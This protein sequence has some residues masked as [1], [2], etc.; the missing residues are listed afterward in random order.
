[1]FRIVNLAIV[2]LFLLASCGHFSEKNLTPEERT[3]LQR[4][5]AEYQRQQNK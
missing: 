4:A 2:A 3:K 1:M 5:N